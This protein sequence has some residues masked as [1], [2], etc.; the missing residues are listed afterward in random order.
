LEAVAFIEGS[1]FEG[2][3]G[4]RSG[5]GFDFPNVDAIGGV[6]DLIDTA[7]EAEGPAVP[8]KVATNGNLVCEAFFRGVFLDFLMPL[9]AD[10]GSPVSETRRCDALAVG[11]E[12]REL[13]Y[14]E[15]DESLFR[16][17]FH[18]KFLSADDTK[19]TDKFE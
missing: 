19:D 18:F 1:G 16:I 11:R 13:T 12:T 4:E 9:L 14:A 10:L 3:D 7:S 17:D 8:A 5:D 6:A 15:Y 2:V